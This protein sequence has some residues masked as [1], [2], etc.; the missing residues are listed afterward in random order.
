MN[1]LVPII[2]GSEKDYKFANAIKVL[3]D[4]L[5]FSNISFE[6]TIRICSAHKSPLNL[7][8]MLSHYDRDNR[9]VY[10]ITIAGKSNALS[11]LIDCNSHKPVISNPPI[12]HDNIYDI[13]SSTSLP[14]GVCPMLVLGSEN[15]YLA[16]LKMLVNTS[17]EVRDFVINYHDNN[18]NKLRI[19]DIKNKNVN[20]PKL[21]NY[22]LTKCINNNYSTFNRVYTGKCRDV[23]EVE[24][25]NKVLFM[26]ATDRCSAFDRHITEIPYKGNVLNSI[27]AFW[28][29]RTKELI[30]NHFIDIYRKNN[31]I[32]ER[33]NTMIVKKCKPFMIEFVMRD[34][35]TGSTQTSIWVN[36]KNGCRE[37]CG[38]KLEEGLV[39]NQKLPQ[40]LLTP[41]TKGEVDESISLEEIVE[42]NIMTQEEVDT[43]KEYS[44]KLFNYGKEVADKR[45]M[46]LVDTKY[47]FGRDQEGNIVLI[48][49]LHTP[50]SSRYWIK[51]SY[52]SRVDNGEEPE[53]ID[54]DL[55]RKYISKN[56]IELNDEIGSKIPNDLV[57]LTTNRYVQLYEILTGL[58][59]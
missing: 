9:V 5:S 34:Y 29:K 21:D 18:V 40:T 54:K 50:D 16:G 1:I 36:Y 41:T 31:T 23:Y 20:L 12:K 55:I 39:K 14:S 19:E 56:K 4:K 15:A 25:D 37:F 58:E 52:Q 17:E 43:C 42:R 53:N 59:F 8:N 2:I 27:S 6:T 45:G 24:E 38:N 22:E 35:M 32:N 10:Y 7:L 30:P 47:E 49:E 13:H 51:H 44:F 48:D 3:Y 28:L 57:E 26:K 33:S 11:A 46:I